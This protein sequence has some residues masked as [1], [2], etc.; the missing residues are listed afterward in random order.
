M[1]LQELRFAL[2]VIAIVGSL[3]LAVNL[4]SY[5]HFLAR[6]WGIMAIAWALNAAMWGGLLSYMQF[7]K[8]VNQFIASEYIYT[9]VN[10]TLM[11]INAMLLA[12]VPIS[13][14]IAFSRMN[15]MMPKNDTDS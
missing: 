13:L 5:R 11:T 10:S 4:F 9:Q 14:L 3:A 12:I 8:S 7:G 15:G 1:E 6:Y 2:Y